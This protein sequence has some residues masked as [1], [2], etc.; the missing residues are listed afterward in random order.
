MDALQQV[1]LTFCL[2][3]VALAAGTTTT[4]STTGTTTYS[5]RGKAATK[6]AITNGATPVLDAATGLAFP[7]IVAN[8]GTVVVIGLD[9]SGAIKASQGSIQALDVSGNF[10]IAPQLP[11]V[12]D[13]MCPIGYIVLKG[14]STLVSTWTFGTNNLSA[15][16][17]MTYTFVD[18]ITLPDRP[19]VA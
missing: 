17:G 1:P 11:T 3:K 9:A 6:A 7:P 16:T 18:L 19:Q 12:P 14:G 4:I 15:V 10:I 2:S 13:T 8:Q 5:V